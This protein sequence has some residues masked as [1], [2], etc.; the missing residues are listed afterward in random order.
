[1]LFLK[2]EAF[3]CFSLIWPLFLIFIIGHLFANY[4][5]VT[6]IIM[7]TLNRNRLHILA[8][9]YYQKKSILSPKIVNKMEP[10]L[11]EIDRHFTKISLGCSIEK[12]KQTSD[13]QMN[14]FNEE[15]FC[16]SIDINKKEAHILLHKSS[17]DMTQLKALFQ[18]EIIENSLYNFRNK[19]LDSQCSVDNSILKYFESSIKTIK[20]FRVY[21]S[22]FFQFFLLM[23]LDKSEIV[24]RIIDESLQKCKLDLDSFINKSEVYGWSFGYTQLSPLQYRYQFERINKNE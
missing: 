5:A 11:R 22:F 3:D 9:N 6:S 4:K 18:L 12:M 8:S 20:R 13:T 23:N 24:E 2:F 10:V 21:F 17:N 16:L 7:E 1:V 14:R 19:N 15:H